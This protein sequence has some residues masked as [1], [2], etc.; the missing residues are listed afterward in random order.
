MADEARYY[1]ALGDAL[2][3]DAYAGGPGRGAP[4][5]LYKNRSD[6]FPEWQGR[7]LSTRLPGARLIPLAMDGA[8]A[9]TLHFAQIPRLRGMDVRASVATVTVG[10]GDLLQASAGEDAAR[11]AHKALWEHGHAVLGALR[12]ELVLPDAPLAV[13]TV[14][15]PSDGAGGALTEWIARCNETLRSLAAEHGAVVADV[16][17]R[18]LGHG[19]S[20]GDPMQPDPRPEARGL[21]YSGAAGPIPV[22]NAWGASEIRTALWD[23]L[24][25]SGML[26]EE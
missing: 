5:L 16:H 13:A 26:K 2:S 11:A 9:A 24:T 6:D 22:P 25:G 20:A 17:A 7:D 10:T 21:W 19:L 8:T 23:A 12:S 1:V 18:L 15:D 3:M 4:A 14:P